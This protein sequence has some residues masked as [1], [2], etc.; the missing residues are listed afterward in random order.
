MRPSLNSMVSKLS[1]PGSEYSAFTL[2]RNCAG[3]FSCSRTK[4][5]ASSSFPEDRTCGGR[6]HISA[7][8]WLYVLIL[9][10]LSTTRTPSAV[11]SSV[12][13][14]SDSDLRWSTSAGPRLRLF[15][16]A[17]PFFFSGLGLYPDLVPG[18]VLLEGQRYNCSYR[19]FDSNAAHRFG[20]E[21]H[22]AAQ[23]RARSARS[24]I[25]C[26]VLPR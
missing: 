16:I 21:K 23:H 18:Q 7:N 11:D 5:R 19:A 24:R 13:R 12:A 4:L 17:L 25:G 15:L 9:P 22:E 3:S 2:S 1:W 26:P 14:S 6:R 8:C 10:R 20:D